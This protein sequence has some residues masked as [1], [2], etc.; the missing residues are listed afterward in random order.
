M[1]IE[2]SKPHYHPGLK[3]DIS[4]Y[5]KKRNL[6]VPPNWVTNERINIDG[7]DYA[8]ILPPRD[9]VLIEDRQGIHIHIPLFI[10]I[11][12]NGIKKVAKVKLSDEVFKPVVHIDHIEAEQLGLKGGEEVTI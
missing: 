4:E 10:E 12:I 3:E 11:E 9:E 7:K 6:S 8:V 5:T 1:K 2:I